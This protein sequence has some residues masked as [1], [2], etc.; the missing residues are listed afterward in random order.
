MLPGTV[1][2]EANRLA[3]P[4]ADHARWTPPAQ[5]ASAILFLASDAAAAINGAAVPVYGRS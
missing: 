4:D 5:I 2:T 3:V 1:D